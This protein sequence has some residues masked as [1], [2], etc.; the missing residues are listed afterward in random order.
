MKINYYKNGKK[1]TSSKVIKMIGVD[2]FN[3]QKKK[4][5][6]SLNED[7]FSVGYSY[8]DH[9]IGIKIQFLK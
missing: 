3:K 1:V 9:C 4:A 7:S 2:E 6:E 8:I 5:M